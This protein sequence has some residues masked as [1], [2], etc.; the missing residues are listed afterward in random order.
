MP[1]AAAKRR[2]TPRQPTVTVLYTQAHA[3][4]WSAA[5]AAEHYAN[6]GKAALRAR[7]IPFSQ[8]TAGRAFSML[9]NLGAQNRFV[10]AGTTCIA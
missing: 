4:F 5:A 2:T 8:T 6:V 1:T 7:A 3:A 10:Q 9:K